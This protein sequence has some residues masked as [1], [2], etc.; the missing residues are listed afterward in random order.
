[1]YVDGFTQ[2]AWVL[3][4]HLKSRPNRSP[5]VCSQVRD[6]QDTPTYSKKL[7]LIEILKKF[8]FYYFLLF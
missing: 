6:P 7:N 8:D 1:M 3:S 2:F 5:D 4:N